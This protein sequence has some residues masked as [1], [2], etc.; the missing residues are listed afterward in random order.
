MKEIDAFAL[1]AAAELTPSQ[2]TLF[3][4]QYRHEAKSYTT[5][6]LLAIFTGWWAGGH[7]FYL[8]RVRGGILHII[9]AIF[10]LSLFSWVLTIIDIFNLRQIVNQTNAGIAADII[11]RIRALGRSQ[12][13]PSDR[14]SLQS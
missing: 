4:N 5:A 7:N 1:Q 9:L 2:Q 11:A 8:G 12:L 14:A 10:T 13:M 3:Y 6:L